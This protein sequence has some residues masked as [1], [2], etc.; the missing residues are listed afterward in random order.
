MPAHEPLAARMRPTSLDEI[1]GQLHLLGPGSA[2]RQLAESDS[3]TSVLLWGPPGTGKT[4]IAQAIAASTSRRFVELSA[5][6]A[7]VKEVR[8]A[9]AAAGKAL[10]TDGQRTVLFIDEIHRFSKAQQ[11]ILLPAVEQGTVSLIGAT[12][13]NPSFAVNAALMSRSVLLTLRSLSEADLI[14]V[15]Q[16]AL[17]SERGLNNAV[18][19]ELQAIEAIARSA[20]GDA[21]QALTLLEAV[22]NS[23]ASQG[24]Q[25]VNI[26]F[27]LEV[28][29]KAIARYDK[30]GDQHYD[31]ISAFIK[32]MR[33]SD[34]QAALHWLARMIEAGE[35]PRFI[36]RRLIVHA[37]EDVGM[38]DPSVLGVAV[39]AAQAVQL[40]GMP[41]ARINLAQAVVAIATAPKSPGIINGIDSA[42]ADVRAGRTGEVP[43]HLRDAHYPGA[44]ALGHGRG[45]LFPHD[46]P[47]GIVAQTYLP[48]EAMGAEY[49]APTQN[50]FEK[51]LGTRMSAIKN[52]NG[53]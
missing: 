47:Y 4:S 45:Y 22:A 16:S 37:S 32:S 26:D 38:A 29:P 18:S 14:A 42:L 8:D 34:P 48:N 41:E 40:I 25:N 44:K 19:F 31:I 9:I 27:V 52:L 51:T 23:A 33:G 17:G 5:T 6:S 10:A 15:L 21:R 11:D 50:G 3:S 43:M 53:I 24:L 2:L 36:A 28:A 39:A 12:T 35:D 13:E 46:F 30:D 20:S 7:G 1:V 49:Y